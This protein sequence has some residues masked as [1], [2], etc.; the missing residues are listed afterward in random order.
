M[1][2]HNLPIGPV[3]AGAF[4]IALAINAFFIKSL[5]EKINHID[6]I[7]TM[8]ATHH[9][10]FSTQ[11]QNLQTQIASLTSQVN[12]VADL[13]ARIAVLEFASNKFFTLSPKVPNI[14]GGQGE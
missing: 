10:Q 8:L 6:R 11:I 4:S 5:V 3:S 2:L 1:D 13:R 12:A 9:A 7:E 14:S